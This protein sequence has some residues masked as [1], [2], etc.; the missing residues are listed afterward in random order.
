[1]LRHAGRR[2]GVAARA[3]VRPRDRPR[4]G[5]RRG[6]PRRSPLR[7]NGKNSH[8]SP[9]PVVDGDRVYVHFGA[10]GTA[11]LTTAARSL[12]QDALPVRVPAWQRR[13]AGAL[14]RPADRQLRRQRRCVRR[15]RSTAAPAKSAGGPT[16][17]Q[18]GRP[19]LLD[20]ARHPRRRSRS[21]R[22]C[23]RL[24]APPP[25]I[26]ATGKEIW[27]VSYGDGFSNVPRPVYRPRAGL[28]RD[29]VPAAVAAGSPAG[30]RGDVTNTHVA[31]TLRRAAPLH[32]FAAARRRRVVHRQRR[33]DR[34]LP[35]RQ[36]RRDRTGSSASAATFPHRRS[37]RMDAS[38]FRVRMASRPSSHR[39][40]T[41][42][43]LAANQ[44]DGA[45]LASMAVG[46]RSLFIRTA[47]HLY[48]LGVPAENR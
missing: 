41:F 2:P 31:W 33:R 45:T 20:A 5:E 13:L 7:I 19:G 12:W 23:R 44:L 8:A 36:D 39:S 38:T 18:P 28:H 40:T 10:E 15:R 17:A 26:R 14:R 48:R 11:A 25:T 43:R 35:G 47:T 9:T 21:G 32:A 22:E 3:G 37:S 4:G 42:R 34:H 30:R 46:E 29:R 1:M 24:S 16:G 27:R 6:V